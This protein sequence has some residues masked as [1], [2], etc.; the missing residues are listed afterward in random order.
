MASP[1]QWTWG[2]VNS[3]S[4]WWTGRAGVLLSMGSQESDT[5]EPLKWT[6][7]NVLDESH[8]KLKNQI[9][10]PLFPWTVPSLKSAEEYSRNSF[11]SGDKNL[12][13]LLYT[14]LLLLLLLLSH[15][16]CVRV[17]ATPWTAAHQAPLSTGFS[18]QEYWSG[19]PF[20]SPTYCFC[21]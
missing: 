1:T 9:C 10:F 4:W 14:D 16:S 20:P 12:S 18:R 3:R 2:W 13:L 21:C 5:T 19:L 7:L 15:F 6:E 17:Y 11:Y 8:W